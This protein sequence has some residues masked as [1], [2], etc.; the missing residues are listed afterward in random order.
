MQTRLIRGFNDIL[1]EK[2]KRWHHIEDSAREQFEL[3]GFSE[4]RTPVLEFTEL[5]ARSIGSTTDI[6][7]KE[8]YTFTDRDGSSLSLRPEGTAGVVRSFIEHSMAR[9]T[10]VS[11]LY[12]TATMFRHERPQKGRYRC[13][14]QIGAEYFGVDEPEADTE[15]IAMLWGYFEKLGVTEVLTLEI[16]SLGDKQGRDEYKT[17]LVEFLTPLSDKLCEDCTRRLET[18]PLR[19]LDCKRERCCE[20]TARAPSILDSLSDE[21]GRHFE[22][23]CGLLDGLK[24]PYVI[25]PRIVRGLDYYCRTVFE[26]TTDKLGAQNSVAAGGRYDGLV[27]ELGSKPTPAVGFALGIERLILLH[28]GL[29]PEGF[30][31]KVDVCMLHLG[32]KAAKVAFELA[33]FL[34]NAGVHVEIEF[35]GKSLK[36]QLKR[37]NRHNARY[38]L[39]LGDDELSQGVIKV[40][41]MVE[42]SEEEIPLED[43]RKHP[44]QF[45]V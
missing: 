19:I 7:E 17:R 20:V 38:A 2:I 39:I 15:L 31:K 21:S 3:Y 43:V 44:H 35:G 14:N 18:N 11:K 10:A 32:E 45:K 24:I 36:G 16:S 33:Q 42:S 25:N 27:E 5:F 1:P 23:L 9:K 30:T 26:V 22:T 41:N 28:E 34:R 13:F 4:I 8:M 6:V 12:Y 37:A 40:R 29:F